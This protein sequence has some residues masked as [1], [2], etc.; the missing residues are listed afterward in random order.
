MLRGFKALDRVL[1]GDATRLPALQQGTIDIPAGLLVVVL[2]ILGMAAGA[3]TGVF[4]VITRYHTDPDNLRMGWEQLAA[5]TVK[6]P[7]LF[8]LTLL[9]TFPSLYVFNALVGSRLSMTG[10]LRLLVAAMCVIMAVL[11]SLGPIVAFFALSTT[12]YPFMKLLTVVAY[13]IA[14]SL[15]LSFLLQTLHR[16]SLAQEA[17][18]MA[19]ETPPP[20]AVSEGAEEAVEG[21]DVTGVPP[22][23]P[24]RPPRPPGALERMAHR[25]VDPRVRTIFQIWVIVFGLVGAQMSWVLRPFIG[26]P[27]KPFT[28]F[29]ERESHFFEGV[30]HAIQKLL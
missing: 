25:P 2:I 27:S 8:C 16:L 21:G 22:Y 26:D 6:V 28:L 23:V 12:S 3:C 13:A 29:R 24:P 4:A 14:G 11:A 17:E 10:M 19:T 7:L 30:W 18:P 5:S 9:V 20:Q 1:R 15:G